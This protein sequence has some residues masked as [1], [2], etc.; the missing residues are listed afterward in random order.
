MCVRTGSEK[1]A[2]GGGAAMA[3][4][5]AGSVVAVAGARGRAA[6]AWVKEAMPVKL[7]LGSSVLPA[8]TCRHRPGLG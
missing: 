4:A 3:E 1:G 6:W 8:A 7:P 5:T 2:E